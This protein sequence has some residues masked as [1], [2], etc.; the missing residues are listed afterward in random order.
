[1]VEIDVVFML[2]YV[3]Y[4]VEEETNNLGNEKNE[5]MLQRFLPSLTLQQSQLHQFWYN[6]GATL[7][8]YWSCSAQ[9]IFQTWES[10]HTF[11]ES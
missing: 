7:A 1:M 11:L 2:E 8:T 9:I 10:V 3:W 6:S 4:K 5:L